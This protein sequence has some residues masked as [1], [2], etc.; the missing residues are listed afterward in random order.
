[1]SAV[2]ALAKFPLLTFAADTAT[3]YIHHSCRRSCT[4]RRACGSSVVAEAWPRPN[5]LAD[6]SGNRFPS[7]VDSR[8]PLRIA[9]SLD[10]RTQTQTAVSCPSPRAQPHCFVSGAANSRRSFWAVLAMFSA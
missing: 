1:M 4:V 7:L 2:S 6:W 5:P 9:S 8:A 10:S 3:V